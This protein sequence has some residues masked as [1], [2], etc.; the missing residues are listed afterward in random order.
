[1]RLIRVSQSI[2]NYFI[3]FER[4]TI[5]GALTFGYNV[6]V[7]IT[8]AAA[9]VLKGWSLDLKEK[10]MR[11][12]SGNSGN[13]I[14]PFFWQHGEDDPVLI[15]ELHRIYDSGIRAVCVESRPHDGF[16]TDEWWDDMKLLLN[17]CERL[18]MEMWIL[19]D[20]YFP[21]GFCNGAITKKY[22]ERCKR[23]LIERHVDVCG[24]IAD[25]A[26]ILDGWAEEKAEDELFAVIACRAEEDGT[27]DLT[28]E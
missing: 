8:L 7:K 13:H 12:L 20:K 19:D 25:G 28:G 1:M 10:L 24:P 2:R 18:G 14:L 4:Q 26:V 21:T 3:R 9:G 6:F 22:P 27:Q 5:D 11:A 16:V 15:D 23:A 17:E